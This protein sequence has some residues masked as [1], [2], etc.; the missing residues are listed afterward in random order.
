MDEAAPL[1]GARPV[2]GTCESQPAAAEEAL[3]PHRE[4]VEQPPPDLQVET[5]AAQGDLH[6][7]RVSE[8]L[9]RLFPGL[10]PQASRWACLEG[11]LSQQPTAGCPASPSNPTPMLIGSAPPPPQFSLRERWDPLNSALSSFPP[12]LHPPTTEGWPHPPRWAPTLEEASRVCR[13]R[14]AL[15]HLGSPASAQRVSVHRVTRTNPASN[16]PPSF[17]SSSL[18]RNP[19]EPGAA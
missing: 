19:P 16:T 12:S 3:R 14:E 13:I 11:F 4:E 6:S 1:W 10:R 18:A 5:P 17:L 9:D 7:W 15:E 2:R 8:A